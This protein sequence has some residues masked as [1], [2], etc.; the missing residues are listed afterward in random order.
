M[1]G[2][3]IKVRLKTPAKVGTR[4]LK[5]GDEEVTAEEKAILEA[6]GLL[7]TERPAVAPEADP[8][9]TVTVT[10]EEFQQAVAVQAKALADAV[11]DAA[12]EEACA[13]II[14]ERDQAK[15]RVAVLEA[16][17]A[18]QTTAPGNAG[19]A[20]AADSSKSPPDGA[21]APAETN[22]PPSEKAAKTAPKKAAAAAT[23]G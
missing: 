6:E 8:G 20:G 5:E 21:A 12:I 13:A 15:A 7:E 16:Q 3:L 22:N 10:L 18:E 9:T 2:D 11:T 4:W 17:I 1:S 19:G 14:Q 23:K